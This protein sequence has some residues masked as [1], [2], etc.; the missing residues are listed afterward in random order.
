MISSLLLDLLDYVNHLVDFY[1]STLRDIVD[2]HAPL[3][4]KV[5][6]RRSMLPLYNKNIQTP[7][8]NIMHSERLWINTSLCVHSEMFNVSIILVKNT[9]ASAKSEYYNKKIKA[10]QG[11]Q[12][13]IFSVVNKVLHKSQTVLPNIIN[14][15]TNMV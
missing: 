15:D 11:N 7:K 9:L 6:P 13:T 14:S 8:R 10:S 12:R 5:M 3:S 2:E 1:D 4:T